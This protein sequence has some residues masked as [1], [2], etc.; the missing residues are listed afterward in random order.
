M[1]KIITV[2]AILIVVILAITLPLAL[3]SAEVNVVYLESMRLD[4]P[5]DYIDELVSIVKENEDPYVRERAVFTL[6]DIAIEGNET[7]EI[8]DFLKELAMNETDDNVRTAAY[9]NIDLIR[10]LYPPE[11][12]GAIALYFLGD[13]KKGSEVSLV[14]EVSSATYLNEEAILGITSLPDGIELLSPG[15]LKL[16]LEANIP[17]EVDFN[18]RLNQTGEYIIAVA[19]KLSFDRIDYEIIHKDVYLV[20]NESDGEFFEL[21]PQV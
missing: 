4:P 16:E 2:P 18:L 11:K 13:I 5:N 19:L 15:V 8:V 6:V 20:V 14:A 3:G 7:E 21:E 9:A 1:K 10:D 17:Q 12:K